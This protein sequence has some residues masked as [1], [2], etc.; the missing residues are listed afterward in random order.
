[1]TVRVRIAPS[2]TG[3]PHVGTAY[4]ALFNYVF[5]KKHGGQFVLRIED[6][7]RAR[8]T[9]DSEAA[10]LGALRW[11]GLGWDEGPDIGGPHGPYRQSERS[12]IY[13]TEA[14]KLVASGAAYRCFCTAERLERM[15]AAAKGKSFVGYD[16]QCRGMDRAEA[17]RRA[18][19]G[20]AFVIRLAMPKTGET[21]VSDRLRGEVRFDNTQIDDQILLKSDGFPTYHLANVVDDH[22]MQI[23]HILRAQE[24]LASTPLHVLLYEGLGWTPP[25]YCHLPMVNGPDGQKLSKRHG[26]TR[27]T[28][29]RDK[30]YLPEALLNYVALLGWSYDAS[31][32][33][34]SLAEL[35][36][37]FSLE[38]L[39]KASAQFDYKKLDWFNGVYIRKLPPERLAGL[40]LPYL[41]NEGLVA[42]PPSSREAELARGLV[43]L[44][45]E[46]LVLLSDVVPLARFLF[47]EVRPAAEDLVPRKLDRLRAAELLRQAAGLLEGFEARDEQGN[48]AAFR[49]LAESLGVK[50]GDLLQPLRVAVTG[51]RASPPLFATLALLGAQEALA[52][53][54]RALPLLEAGAAG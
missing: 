25:A 19:A 18:A 14:A 2:P 12:E 31:T 10:I 17:D 21:V 33:L 32:E 36:R 35:E 8:S 5:A 3:D 27:V 28:E 24:W 7:D 38:R 15:R 34:F 45:Q 6:T 1:M 48:E 51:S 43:P 9:A 47:R 42:D 11:I 52:R 23:T 54:R 44:V 22:L 39:N 13:K 37:L 50:L 4:I 46:R 20:E 41:R 40:L 26:A 53:V 16:G 49:G 29:F 30:G